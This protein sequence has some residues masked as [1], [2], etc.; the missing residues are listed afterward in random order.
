VFKSLKEIKL[1]NINILQSSCLLLFVTNCVETKSAKTSLT[2][3][4]NYFL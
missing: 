2:L 3:K 4:D 1:L